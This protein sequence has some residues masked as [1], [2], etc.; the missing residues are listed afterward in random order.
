MKNLLIKSETLEKIVTQWQTPLIFI[1][2]VHPQ[3]SS[4]QRFDNKNAVGNNPFKELAT[5]AIIL[6]SFP[7][8]NAV[9]FGFALKELI[10]VA[11]N[12]IFLKNCYAL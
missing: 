7:F 5:L 11:I 6:L 10:S 3:S 4:G 9:R 2:K 1:G 8:S 12:I